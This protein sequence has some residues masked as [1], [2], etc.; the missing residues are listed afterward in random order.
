MSDEKWF[1]KYLPFVA[2]SLRIQ[3][4][5]L[6][7][8]LSRLGVSDGE[9]KSG[10]LSR[11]EIKPYISLLLEH[12]SSGAESLGN[13]DG[14]AAL[15]NG[16]TNDNLALMMECA[17]VYDVPRLFSLLRHPTLEMAIIAVKKVP[18]TYEKNPLLVI[19]RVFLSIK[20]KSGKL[21]EEAAA[22]V[23][24]NDAPVDFLVNYERF[25][26]IMM[27]EHVLSLLYPKAK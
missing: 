16:I 18:P 8:Q 23:A 5:W 21:L 14:M 10:V 9:E 19:D 11:D 4:E 25:K 27:D 2:K 12:S 17:D 20:G 22:A 26:E 3:V 1:E 6:V 13:D 15:L 7:D 24:A